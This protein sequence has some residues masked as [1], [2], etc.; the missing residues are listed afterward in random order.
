MNI[1][2]NAQTISLNATVVDDATG[3][4][5]PYASIYVSPEVGSMTNDAGVFQLE[6]EQGQRIRISYVGYETLHTSVAAGEQTYRLRPLTANMNE[7]T[8]LPKED[9]MLNVAK[10]LYKEFR[11]KKNKDSDYF[12]RLTH[13]FSGNT[14]MVE[15]F[16]RDHPEFYAEPLPLPAVFS[17]NESGM[18]VLIPGEYDT[19]GFFICRLRRKL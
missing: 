8:V 1:Y 10:R 12:Y 14:E 11:W 17:K 13:S 2:L 15:A 18:Q 6:L 5:L 3:E 9:I 7:I 4:P 16:L 19:D